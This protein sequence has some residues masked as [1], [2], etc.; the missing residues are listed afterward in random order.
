MKL[1]KS[2]IFGFVNA[3]ENKGFMYKTKGKTSFAIYRNMKILSKV[4]ED[5]EDARINAIDKYGKRLEDGSIGI[6]E[7]DKEAS[8]KFLEETERFFN[9]EVEVDVFQIEE[10]EFELP[11]CES[12]TPM[13]YAVI[14]AIL[15]KNGDFK[16][17]FI[18]E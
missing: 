12:A 8:Q 5:L 3:I 18:R 14:E 11:Y 1:C 7:N 17:L 16:E 13:E 4:I 10:D 2:F 6:E 15:V 9:D